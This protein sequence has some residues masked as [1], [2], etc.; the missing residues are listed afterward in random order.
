MAITRANL[1]YL[2][3]IGAD[4]RTGEVAEVLGITPADVRRLGMLKDGL[5]PLRDGKRTRTYNAGVVWRWLLAHPQYDNNPEGKT[6]ER[7][8]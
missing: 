8:V 3:R 7:R 6:D 2:A 1:H 4:L 5:H